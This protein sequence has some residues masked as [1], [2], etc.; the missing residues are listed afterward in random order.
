MFII[1]L[2]SL[3]VYFVGG[4]LAG[5]ILGP[6]LGFLSMFL[7][8]L[9]QCVVFHDGGITTLGANVL[10]MAIIDVLVGY[11]LYKVFSKLNRKGKLVG[12][13][14]GGWLGITLAGIACGF[15][16][17]LSP[18]FPYGV[19]I[20]VPIMGVWHAVLGI[21]EGIITMLIVNYILSKHPEIII[22]IR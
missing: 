17:G 15:E 6:Y 7:V 14:L 20:S 10:N 19:T 5:I 11:T 22:S 13:F 9:I 18:A 4:A 21:I 1:S 3:T 2:S 12:A 16:I 8:L